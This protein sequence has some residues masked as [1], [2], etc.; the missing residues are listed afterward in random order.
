MLQLGD[1]TAAGNMPPCPVAVEAVRNSV[2]SSS[3]YV[4]ACGTTEARKAIAEYHSHYHPVEEK[5]VIVASGCSGA[6]ELA[7]TALL[8]PN[9]I[10]LVPAPGFSLYQ[11]IAESHGAQVLHYRLLP[12]KQWQI[13]LD[14]VQELLEQHKG[15]I[16]GI[17]VN[18]PS[19]PTGAVY[20]EEHLQ[21]V[22]RVCRDWQIPVIS[23]E[24]Y[25]ELSFKPFVSVARV[26][27]SFQVPV[28][29]ASGLGKQ[30]LVPGWRLGWLC[31]YDK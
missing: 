12:D 10:L 1:P 8:N 29:V 13:D 31:V 9:D 7:L 30:F 14:H 25:G 5:H 24:I 17:V 3:S 11:V 28:I 23:D 27:S 22:C 16:K 26:A 21:D 15:A 20:T 2:S 6:L 4:P 19:N 18:T